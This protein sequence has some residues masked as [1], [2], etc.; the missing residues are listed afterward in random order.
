M[1]ASMVAAFPT[2]STRSG[3]AWARWAIREIAV[4]V[5]A[6][7]LIVATADVRLPIGLPGHRGLIWLT[8]LVV[9]AATSRVRATVIAVGVTATIGGLVAHGASWEGGRYV[10]AASALALLAGTT[11]VRRRP[12]LLAVAAAPIHLVAVAVPLG[13]AGAAGLT[14]KIVG[15]LIFGLAAGALGVSAAV[16]VTHPRSDPR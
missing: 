5:V 9:V 10:V 13:L 4:P 15:H 16:A 8:L 12:W 6:G 3:P 2:L 11:A 14:A 1:V 7:A